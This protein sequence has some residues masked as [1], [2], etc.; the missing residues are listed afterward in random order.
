MKSPKSRFEGKGIEII[1]LFV[2]IAIW[3]LIA[4]FVIQRK[5]ILPSFTDVFIA[6]VDIIQ[7]GVFFTDLLTS[8]LHFGIG[9][10]AALLIGIPIGVAMGWFKYVD[11]AIDPLIEIVRPIPPLAWIPFAIVWF[12]LTNI[13][14]GFVIFVGAVFPIVINTVSGFK[15]VPKVYVE[16]A[17]VLGCMNDRSLI[18]HV[19]LPSSF[20]SI[21]AGI[22]IA[23]G[24]GWMCLVAAEM[25]GV[26]SSGLGYKIWWH[27][28]L[29]QMDY[30]LVYM[31]ILGFLG[32]VIDRIFRWYVDGKILKWRKGVVV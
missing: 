7:S 3:Q 21:A 28:Y 20:P 29:H 18:R 24:V 11:K 9:L 15:G 17:R 22:R 30:V 1:S 14:A 23:M 6:F 5:L 2:A 16:A 10:F 13:S 31:L 4:D 26:S 32:L 19:A 12:G 8:L 27:Y 25:F